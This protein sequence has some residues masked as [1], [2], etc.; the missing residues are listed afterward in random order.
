MRKT[1]IFLAESEA[2][3]RAALRVILENQ[4][5]FSIIGEASSAESTLAQ[6]CQ[7]HPDM[8]LLDWNL[9]GINHQRLI[10]TLQKHCPNTSLVATSVKPEH[11][12]TA[13]QIG[14]DAFISKQLQPDEFLAALRKF[15]T[16]KETKHYE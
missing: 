2:H 9:T 14:S 3:V 13:Y 8:I 16:Q 12:L 10:Y 11:E 1:T 7:K 6:I 5:D 15:I 4:A